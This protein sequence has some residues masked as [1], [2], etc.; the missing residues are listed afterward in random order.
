MYIIGELLL[1]INMTMNGLLLL[2][3]GKLMCFSTSFKRVF[4]ASLVGS[5][6][7]F[8]PDINGKLLI[9]VMTSVLMVWIA[10]GTHP[11][12][13]ML[14]GLLMFYGVSSVIGGSILGVIFLFNRITPSNMHRMTIYLPGNLPW[15]Y[16]LLSFLVCVLVLWG[17]R[18]TERRVSVKQLTLP[19]K[20]TVNGKTSI[21]KVLV[22]TGNQ[23]KTFT[24]D[25][26]LVVESKA[27]EHI[28]TERE[29]NFISLLSEGGE[30]CLED[31]APNVRFFPLWF[32][33]LGS[34]HGLLVGFRPEK[35]ELCTSRNDDDVKSQWLEVSALVAVTIKELHT[36]Q[37][38]HGLMPVELLKFAEG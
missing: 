1:L 35:L 29:K 18:F 8:L 3:T 11:W 6:V 24:G 10:F 36:E 21:I 34:E 27:L 26:C 23:L 15:T 37:D 13:R 38:S 25:Y 33:S 14:T 17:V 16:L 9:K 4:W 19:V 28:I 7:L 32:Q 2:L 22:D 5:L 12:R 20:L 31:Y 30:G